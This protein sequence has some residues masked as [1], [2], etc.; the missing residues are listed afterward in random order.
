MRE[1]KNTRR[2]SGRR[3]ELGKEKGVMYLLLCGR[4]Q[5]H[6]S[7]SGSSSEAQLSPLSSSS[8]SSYEW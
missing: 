6:Q 5:M 1:E 2:D 4:L 8:S 3:K 7:L